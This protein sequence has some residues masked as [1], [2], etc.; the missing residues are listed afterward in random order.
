MFA[1]RGN[2]TF[3]G[4]TEIYHSFIQ[5]TGRQQEEVVVIHKVTGKP[6]KRVALVG[7]EVNCIL[8]AAKR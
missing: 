4:A 1:P 7:Y 3:L 2:C 5:Y 8:I 6:W